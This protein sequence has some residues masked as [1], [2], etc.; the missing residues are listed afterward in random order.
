MF[1]NFFGFPPFFL[2]DLAPHA[3]YF[4]SL[5]PFEISC[6]RFLPLILSHSC[7][8]VLSFYF[9]APRKCCVKIRDE[10]SRVESRRVAS[11][12]YIHTGEERREERRGEERMALL[13]FK[14]SN[15]L[16]F[17][18]LPF[19]PPFRFLVSLSL[20]LALTEHPSQASEQASKLGVCI[21]IYI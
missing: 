12:M 11:Y 13:D 3:S 1:L 15:V 21:Y 10:S 20:Q 2:A 4:L 6:Y 19:H 9:T 7:E 5:S 8:R 18:F 17:S 16:C 14:D